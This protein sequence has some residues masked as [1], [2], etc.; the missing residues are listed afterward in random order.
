M[1]VSILITRPRPAADTFAGRVRE[2]LGVGVPVVVSPLIRIA[3]LPDA[4]PALSG[5]GALVIT[6]A[7]AAALVAQAPEAA[8]LPCYCVGAAT[9]RAARAA[10]L[11]AVEGGGTAEALTRRIIADAP[12]G[13]VLYPRGE[14]V[15]SELAQTL[16]KAGV[17]AHEA[18]IYRQEAKPLSKAATEL[19][20][21]ASPVVVPLFSPR[22]ARLFFDAAP[23]R[24]PLLVAAISRNAAQ[25][26][27]NSV[28]CR[29]AQ[30][31][32][33]DSM[34]DTVATLASHANRVESGAGPQ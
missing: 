22:T 8:G 15:A 14:H 6:S 21:G 29:I 26:V 13:P 1:T 28:H 18:V 24:A 7:H 33:A 5:T 27:T 19:L 23:F 9:A 4:L 12:P 30:R 31:P 34:L 3:P 17:E 16:R 11:D 10:G 32:D 25:A 20:A 2:R